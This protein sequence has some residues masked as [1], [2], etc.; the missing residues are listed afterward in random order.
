MAGHR[1]KSGLTSN[2]QGDQA[3]VDYRKRSPP[4]VSRTMRDWS[5]APRGTEASFAN[6]LRSFAGY[7]RINVV[8]EDRVCFVIRG[9]NGG[10][11]VSYLSLRTACLDG[12]CTFCYINIKVTLQR[13]CNFVH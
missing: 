5:R 2:L 8:E 6:N 10:T 13:G 9:L 7:S 3:V 12:Y 4:Q 1:D 11:M